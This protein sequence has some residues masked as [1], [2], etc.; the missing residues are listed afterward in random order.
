MQLG[1]PGIHIIR[2]RWFRGCTYWCK[3]FAVFWPPTE[4]QEQSRGDSIASPFSLA[5]HRLE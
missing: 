3:Q 1:F 2:T 5:I 4:T